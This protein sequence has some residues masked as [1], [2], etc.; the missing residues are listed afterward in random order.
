MRGLVNPCCQGRSSALRVGY[1]KYRP[2]VKIGVREAGVAR[3]AQVYF[4]HPFDYLVLSHV[5]LA[6]T[7]PTSY[8]VLL[9]SR[10]Q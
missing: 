3:V 9:A 7:S 6:P 4:P 8:L 1:N 10:S 2:S 5:L